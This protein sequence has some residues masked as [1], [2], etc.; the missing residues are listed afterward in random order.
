MPGNRVPEYPASARRAGEEGVVVLKVIVLDTG[1][2]D[3]IEVLRGQ[4]P[5]TDAAIE[6]VKTWQYVPAKQ[7]GQPVTVYRIVQM[8]FYLRAPWVLLRF[9]GT[10]GGDSRRVTVETPS[11]ANEKE[12]EEAALASTA[13]VYGCFLNNDGRRG[14]DGSLTSRQAAPPP[15][16]WYSLLSPPLAASGAP[17]LDRPESEWRRVGTFS[18]ESY[19]QAIRDGAMDL[20]KLATKPVPRWQPALG[21][22]AAYEKAI[23]VLPWTG[24]TRASAVSTPVEATGRRSPP[25]STSRSGSPES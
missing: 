17:A 13:F 21:L 4:Q 12:C 16:G 2:V 20:A 23:E 10:P 6:A 5:F 8:P 18:H 7:R 3:K 1:R 22:C 25:V 15:P 19:C 24:T 11:F 14:A 9:A